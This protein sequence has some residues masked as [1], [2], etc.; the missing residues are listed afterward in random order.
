MTNRTSRRQWI[1]QMTGGFGSIGLA[2]MLDRRRTGRTGT[3]VRVPEL[4]AAG[5]AQHRAVHGGAD[6]RKLDMF[7]YKPALLKYQG[8]RPPSVDLRTERTTGGLL[9]SPFEFKREGKSGTWVS[10]LLPHTASVIDEICV[11]KS[12]YTFNPTHTPRAQ[13]L[14][15][16]E[17]RRHAAV[18]GFVD[19]LRAGH[20]K[21]GSAGLRGAESGAIG[22][23]AVAIRISS[24]APPGH[25][26]R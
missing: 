11:I 24:R 3:R 2:S 7:D 19:F 9:P 18:D 4:Q 21:Q 25:L 6:L 10:S 5:E 14:P 26:F 12:M 20:G 17:Y 15:H 13:P 16:R 8:E 22:E 23:R 1:A